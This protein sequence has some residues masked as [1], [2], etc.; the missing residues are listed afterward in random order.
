M[1][2]ISGVISDSVVIMGPSCTLCQDEAIDE[3]ECTVCKY[4]QHYTCALGFNPPE[5]FKN[6][7]SRA[8]YTCPICVVGSSYDNLHKALESHRMQATEPGRRRDPSPI[9][10]RES[11]STVHED[12][13][14]LDR[15]DT[16]SA[17]SANNAAGD[18]DTQSLVAAA[19]PAPP[20]GQRASSVEPVT[21]RDPVPRQQ[22]APLEKNCALKVKYLSYGLRSLSSNLPDYV[23]TVCI[24]DSL[25][26][27]LNKRDLDPNSNSLRIRSVGGLCVVATVHSLAR[28]KPSHP[29]VKKVVFTMGIND[30][31][32]R[33]SHCH[34]DTD[35]YFKALQVEATR[36]F[37]NA[38]LNFVLPYRGM[39]GQ[40][41]TDAVQSDLQARL[42]TNC[43]NIRVHVPPKLTGMVKK[44]GIHPSESGNIALNKWYRN[45]FIPHSPRAYNPNSGRQLP[46]RQYSA[47][48]EQPPPRS[49]APAAAA[50]RGPAGQRQARSRHPPPHASLAQQSHPS[51]ERA[52]AHRGLA[53]E[54]ADAFGQMMDKWGQPPRSAPRW[55]GSRCRCYD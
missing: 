6:D 14:T 10:R 35:S 15:V 43:P 12:D 17:N 45:K 20:H 18:A 46:G 26:K 40:N 4:A 31:L 7:D 16:A 37:P 2:G 9:E 47:A 51:A 54:I 49:G 33:N 24:G 21:P 1:S 23:T 29:K 22:W 34:E 27:G 25:Q 44:D 19:F 50:G 28:H 5:A 8:S 11:V 52:P 41:I 55:Q 13:V 36:M 30:F 53:G 32:H 3:L 38:T 48:L 42:T 39:S